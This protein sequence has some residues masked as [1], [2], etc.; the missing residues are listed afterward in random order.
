MSTCK[1]SM[2]KHLCMML[3]KTV[4]PILQSYS[5]TLEQMS[6]CKMRMAKR[7]CIEL[8]AEVTLIL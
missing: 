2:A 7:L 8:K 1:I 6:T 5:S 3:Q 4:T